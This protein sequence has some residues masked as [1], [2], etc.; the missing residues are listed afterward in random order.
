MKRARGYTVIEVMI[1]LTLLAI[2]TSGIIAMQKVTSV[3]N[4]ESRNLVIANQIARTWM[5]RLRTDAVQWNNPS[6]ANS[7][8]DLD[9][10]TVWLKKTTGNWE[11]PVDDV[12]GSPTADA[13]GNDVRDD[14]AATGSF[15]TNVRLSWLRGPASAGVAPPFLLRAEVRVYW[16][17]DGGL[18]SIDG[19]P[20]CDPS[21]TALDAISPAIDRYHFVYIT[22]AIAQNMAQ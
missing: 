6:V 22:S 20:V 17:R 13:F 8:S 7:L 18:G 11:R 2:G 14:Q 9:S 16:L 15:C 5:E 1:A 12:R 4:R 19:N 21:M 3:T 10:D